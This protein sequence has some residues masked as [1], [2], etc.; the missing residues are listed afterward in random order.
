MALAETLIACAIVAVML[1][2]TYQAMSTTVSATTRLLAQR[3]ALM[4]A[5]S[6]VARVGSDI[7]LAPGTVEGGTDGL[8]WR[9]EVERYRG[10][11]AGPNDDPALMLV[12]VSV[13][14]GGPGKP[15]FGLRTLKLAS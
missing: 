7:A 8:A 15:A 6:V 9:V 13:G 5:E 14:S 3:R 2:A 10:D 1:G 4:V 12:S 11:G